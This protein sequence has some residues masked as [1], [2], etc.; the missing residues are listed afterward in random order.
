MGCFYA[1]TYIRADCRNMEVNSAI[2]TLGQR[3]NVSSVGLC[4]MKGHPVQCGIPH[5][6]LHLSML[7]CFHLPAIGW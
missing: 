4:G 5:S 2:G 3:A 1:V 6:L 7:V